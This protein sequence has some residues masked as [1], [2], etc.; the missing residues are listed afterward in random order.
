MATHRGNPF[1]KA[2]T[3]S[4]SCRSRQAWTLLPDPTKTI[5]ELN[6]A[7]EVPGS[8]LY[9]Q[10]FNQLEN[11]FL[12]NDQVLVANG[13]AEQPMKKNQLHTIELGLLAATRATEAFVTQELHRDERQHRVLWEVYCDGESRTSHLA[14]AMGMQVERFS[15]STGWDFNLLEHQRLFLE[16]QQEEMPDEI[17]LGSD[18]Q[19]KVTEKKPSSPAAN[20][21]IV[22]TFTSASEST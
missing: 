15:L 18:L 7:E 9:L 3:A 11:I 16:R 12:A 6:I 10:D 2:G 17:M 14:E 4:I 13:I 22:G 1:C 8:H 21:T 5:F 20:D 19:T